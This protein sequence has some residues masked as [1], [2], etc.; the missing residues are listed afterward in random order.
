MVLG[1][2]GSLCWA[3]KASGLPWGGSSSWQM[4]G[5]GGEH[6]CGGCGLAHLS[7]HRLLCDLELSSLS[8]PQFFQ[9][10]E[11]LPCWIPERE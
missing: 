6:C 9:S 8:S 11:F 1:T 4:L 7:P 5:G 2:Q 3:T 10:W